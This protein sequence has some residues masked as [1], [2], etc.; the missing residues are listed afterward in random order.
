[1]LCTCISMYM[2][3]APPQFE[4]WEAGPTGP[5]LGARSPALVAPNSVAV[6]SAP[7]PKKRRLSLSLSWRKRL[8]QLG[9]RSGTARGNCPSNEK[10]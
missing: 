2:Y 3:F 8:G 1:M 10:H 4:D 9:L 7:A 6:E 5:P